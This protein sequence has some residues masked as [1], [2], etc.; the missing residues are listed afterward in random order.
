MISSY[1]GQELILDIIFREEIL[2]NGRDIMETVRELNFKVIISFLKSL[3]DLIAINNIYNKIIE[4]FF[5]FLFISILKIFPEN[6][7]I[8]KHSHHNQ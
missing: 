4:S 1:F 3:S 2:V 8:T 7:I 6:S 5:N